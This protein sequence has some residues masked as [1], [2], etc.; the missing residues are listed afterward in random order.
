MSLEHDWMPFTA[1]RAFKQAPRL[2][3]LAEGSRTRLIGREGGYHDLIVCAKGLST[4]DTVAQSPPLIVSEAQIGLIVQA[5]KAA[6]Q[7]VV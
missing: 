4:G 5:I 3:T 2:M 6:L 1:N 7:R